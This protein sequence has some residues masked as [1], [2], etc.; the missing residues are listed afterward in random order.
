MTTTHPTIEEQMKDEI[1]LFDAQDLADR[2]GKTVY[3][4]A[5]FDAHERVM[6]TV[7][8]LT[9]QRPTTRSRGEILQGV[10]IVTRPGQ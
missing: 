5:L 7:P 6:L 1:D 4:T 10:M 3:A 9:T 8:R 2:T